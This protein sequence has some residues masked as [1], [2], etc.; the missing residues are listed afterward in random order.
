MNKEY[1]KQIYALKMTNKDNKAKILSATSNLSFVGE[2]DDNDKNTPLQFFSG[3]S[4]ILID[5]LDMTKG[6]RY[7]CSVNLEPEDISYLFAKTNHAM[8]TNLIMNAMNSAKQTEASPQTPAYTQKITMGKAKGLT[9]VQAI[10][11]G[12]DLTWNIESLS[13]NVNDPK[14]GAANRK[15][16]AAIQEAMN[17][18]KEKLATQNIA[19]ASTPIV[20]L[21]KDNLTRTSKKDA[22]GNVMV[23]DVQI[24]CDYTRN[25]PYRIDIKNEYCPLSLSSGGRRTAERSKAT[26]TQ[27]TSY[28]M[29]EQD[30]F[31]FINACEMTKNLFA[32]K[33]ASEA[34]ALAN[35]YGWKP[36]TDATKESNR[37][38][39]T[40]KTV[41]YQKAAQQISTTRQT[42]K[43]QPQ[44][45]TMEVKNLS[46]VTCGTAET[47]KGNVVVP[48]K[49]K[50][51]EGGKILYLW[52]T[53]P[54]KVT[55]LNAFI[56]ETK[57][58]VVR[59][60][61]TARIKGTNLQYLGTVN[62]QEAVN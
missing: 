47:R 13:K 39:N 45:A 61:I 60:D 37:S 54:D 38:N 35:K 33:F 24:I 41:E 28:N 34:I 21:K 16:I 57:K 14:F 5:I 12:I 59:L 22:N 36:K 44:Q 4:R 20:L 27:T 1:A 11:Q 25:Y 52:F 10:Q 8:Q 46:V 48:V 51:S 53:A 40:N 49:E 18:P 42:A 23:C 9:P 56:E 17:I 62:K 19:P 43:A 31:S 15:Q 7:A 55:W 50:T 3:Y 58:R 6:P 32:Q 2:N 26:N 30:W 29:T